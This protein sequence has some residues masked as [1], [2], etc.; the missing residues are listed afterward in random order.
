MK[1]GL[2]FTDEHK[3]KISDS[4][5]GRTL[6]DTHKENMSKAKKGKLS[7]CAKQVTIVY[8][9]EERNFNS[10]TECDQW[11]WDNLQ[12]KVFYWLRKSIP[13]KY[14]NDLQFIKVGNEIKFSN[15]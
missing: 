13:K 11:F 14:V 7:N 10:M 3:K 9:N 8:Q 12:I 5:K 6:S 4:L 1:K 2:K 15:Q